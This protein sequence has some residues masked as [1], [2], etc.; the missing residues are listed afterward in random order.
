MLSALCGDTVGRRRAPG[1]VILRGYPPPAALI[2]PP[3]GKESA[4]AE[5][6]DDHCQRPR[7]LTGEQKGRDPGGNRGP[8]GPLGGEPDGDKVAPDLDVD[9]EQRGQGQGGGQ[10]PGPDLRPDNHPHHLGEGCAGA[11][12]WREKRE[13]ADDREQHQPPDRAHQGGEQVRQGTPDCGV[14]GE[15]HQQGNEGH[16]GQDVAES[17]LDRIPGGIAQKGQHLSEQGGE[18]HFGGHHAPHAPLRLGL[19][20]HHRIVH[21][22]AERLR[23][24]KTLPVRL[25]QLGEGDAGD[26]GVVV[27]KAGEVAPIAARPDVDDRD[28]LLRIEAAEERPRIVQ[29]HAQELLVRGQNGVAVDQLGLREGGELNGHRMK[30]TPGEAEN[31]APAAHRQ[32]EAGAGSAGAGPDV[33]QFHGYPSSM[34]KSPR[35]SRMSGAGPLRCRA[36]SCRGVRAWSKHITSSPVP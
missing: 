31:D 1:R 35:R 15:R 34:I 28:M 9:G 16:K 32:P 23:V 8:G 2:I 3:S 7:Q 29:D 11:K 13:A 17:H 26:P 19:L 10:R 21:L 14:L 6:A 25:G 30:I 5:P 22:E 18:T 24:G 12:E 27:D 36:A 20:L 33:D 4:G